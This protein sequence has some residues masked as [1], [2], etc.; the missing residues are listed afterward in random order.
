[1]TPWDYGNY[2]SGAIYGVITPLVSSAALKA[3]VPSLMAYTGLKV[4][5]VGTF[6]GPVTATIQ[7]T[8][9][10]LSTPSIVFL[11]MVGGCVV[12]AQ[13]TEILGVVSSLWNVN[14]ALVTSWYKV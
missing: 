14:N 4:A 11:G 8:A 3:I 10:S 2:S 6:H 1:M 5:G 12:H 13:F 9:A 7:A